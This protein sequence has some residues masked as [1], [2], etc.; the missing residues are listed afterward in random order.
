MH[1]QKLFFKAVGVSSFFGL[2]LFNSSCTAI[3][4]HPNALQGKIDSLQKELDVFK[5]EKAQT[6]KRLAAFDVLDFDTYTHQKWTEFGATHT[7]DVKV[8]Y[9]DGSISVGL[10]PGHIDKMKPQFAFA[11]DTEIKEHP[12]KLGSGD[13]TAVVGVM[14]GTFT[15]PIDLGGGKSIAPTGK[16]FKLSMTTIGHWKGDKMFEEYLFWDNELFNKQIGIGQ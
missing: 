5:A 4:D 1:M 10:T 11:P 7:E 15:K 16:K 2:T 8:F 13:W 9:P 3:A 6:E 14:E 12:I